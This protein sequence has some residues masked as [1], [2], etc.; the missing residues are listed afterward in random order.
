MLE[1]ARWKYILVAIVLVLA[2][3]FALPNVFGEAPALQVA[4]KD[5]NAM[6]ATAQQTVEKFLTDQKVPFVRSLIDNGRLMVHFADVPEQLRARD[7][8][9]AAPQFKDQYITALSFAT[10]AP[11]LFTKLG[12]RPMPFG[13][14]LR[15]GLY[16]LYQVDVSGAINQVLGGYEQAI[17]RALADA[18]IQYLDV[19]P[20]AVDST[21]QNGIRVLLPPNSDPDAVRE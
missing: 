5:H 17:R 19:V 20:V 8:V 2:L 9:N 13:L 16:L 12:I 3:I 1:Y 10:R 11:P 15:G 7:A 4:R 21:R 18:K 6:D 14:D